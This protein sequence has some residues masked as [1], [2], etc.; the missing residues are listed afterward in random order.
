MCLIGSFVR[1][2]AGRDKDRVFVCVAHD[3]GEY[4]YIAD[5]M[6]RKADKPKRKKLRHVEVLDI[7]AS[8]NAAAMTNKQLAKAVRDVCKCIIK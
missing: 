2:K 3:E 8:D 1:S 5:G 6:L 7:P 4:I